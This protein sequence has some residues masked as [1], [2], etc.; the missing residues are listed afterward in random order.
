MERHMRAYQFIAFTAVILIIPATC[1]AQ[2]KPPA[3]MQTSR[4]PSIEGAYELIS[5]TMPDGRIQKPPD[6]M[7]LV[8]YTKNR[9]NMNMYWKDSLGRHSSYSMA[10]TYRLTKTEYIETVL[11]SILNDQVSGNEIKYDLAGKTSTATV[12][13]EGGRIVL[14]LPSDAPSVIFEGETM[15]AS[16]AGMFT[17]RWQKVK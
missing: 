4:V 5:R 11:F 8:T 16:A 12:K 1:T 3:K 14:R 7:G 15:T 6:L 9:R 10:S 2:A 13:I 17:D